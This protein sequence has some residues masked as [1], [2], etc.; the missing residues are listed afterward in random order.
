[1]QESSSLQTLQEIK[2]LMERSSKFLSL[3]GLSGIAMGLIALA[4]A[5]AAYY[6]YQT[7]WAPQNGT[8]YWN[9]HANHRQ[10]MVQ[11]LF[12]DSLSVLVVSLTLVIVLTSRKAYHRGTSVWNS[13]SRRLL[14][15]MATPLLAGGVFCLA[16]LFK[17]PAMLVFP[18]TLIFYGLAL[19]NAGRHTWKEVTYLGFTEIALGC[20]AMF[21]NSYAYL[22]LCW[23]I[24]FGFLHIFYGALMHFRHER[25]NDRMI[26]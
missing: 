6:Q 2:A 1:M 14:Y 22:F 4:G 25:I 23:I 11:F 20:A 24:G 5:A 17:G 10:E 9:L 3:S 21:V 26:E 13:A 15:S 7:A 8:A 12:L 18:A 16:I 19:V